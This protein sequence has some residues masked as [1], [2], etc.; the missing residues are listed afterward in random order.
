MRRIVFSEEEQN[1]L[2]AIGNRKP[3]PGEGQAAALKDWTCELWAALGS[4]LVESVYPKLNYT[5]EDALSDALDAFIKGCE[6]YS[7]EKGDLA[8]YAARALFRNAKTTEGQELSTQSRMVSTVFTDEDGEETEMEFTDG[9]DASRHLTVSAEEKQ[10]NQRLLELAAQVQ[11]L[12]TNGS[13]E[14][15]NSTRA[16]FFPLWFTEK[17]SC[18]IMKYDLIL[19]SDRDVFDAMDTAYLDFFV[20]FP[21]RSSA[22]LADTPLRS[23]QEICPG[24]PEKQLRWSVKNWLPAKVPIQYLLPIKRYGNDVITNSRK[25]YVQTIAKILEASE[26]E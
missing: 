17:A 26:S 23:M 16:L 19:D 1:T 22:A 18:A 8:S 3:T 4:I 13:R 6:A 7:P 5:E 20:S 21:C 25:D 2:N 9:E 10:A 12:Q 11:Y 24:E 14:R 15:K